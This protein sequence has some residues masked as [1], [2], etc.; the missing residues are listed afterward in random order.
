MTAY[1][2]TVALVAA[3]LLSAAG[4]AQDPTGIL[5]RP[6]PTPPERLMPV[7]HADAYR[8]AFDDARLGRLTRAR[9]DVRGLAYP[10]LDTAL[11]WVAL[12]RLF[13]ADFEVYRDFIETYPHWP[14]RERIERSAESVINL[15]VP[16]AD[17]DAWFSVHPPKTG[18]GHL[19]YAD[20]LFQ[21]GRDPAARRHLR[22]GWRTAPLTRSNQARIIGNWGGAL[23][24][25]DH[26]ARAHYWLWQRNRTQASRML[27]LLSADDRALVR[28]RL[29]LIAFA[30]GVDRRVDAVPDAL[31]NHAGLIYDRAYWRRVK[32]L[33]DAARDL[34]L[35]SDVNGAE[36]LRPKRWWRERH[37]QARKELKE[38]RYRNAYRLA[39]E[40]QLYEAIATHA[41]GIDPDASDAEDD[42]FGQA[43]E[44]V[45]RHLR[46]Q[47]AEAE[48]LAGWLALRFLDRP[49]EA[50]DHFRR[51]YDVVNFPVSIA[52][53]GYWTGR[54]AEARGDP[55]T[56]SL[57]YQRAAEHSAFYYGQLA[58]SRLGQPL[59]LPQQKQAVVT[60]EDRARFERD[61]RVQAARYLA[62]LDRQRELRWMIAHLVESAPTPG[63]RSLYLNLG[64]ELNRPDASLAAAKRLAR[65]G[66]LMVDAAY[67]VIQVP[68]RHQPRQPLILAI[69]RQESAFDPGA[70]SHAGAMG[71]MQL[72][73][74]TANLVARQLNRPFEQQ[75][76]VYDPSYNLELGATHIRDLLERYNGSIVLA[77]GAYN[78]GGRPVGRWLRDYGDPRLPDVDVVD[79]V[80][81][82]PYSETRNYVQRV[83]EAAVVYR[84][85]LSSN[86][87]P[88]SLE[89]MLNYGRPD[90]PR[91]MLMR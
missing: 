41:G 17:R 12:R 16:L 67:P 59:S 24:E 2:Y 71:L 20:T 48:F 87:N 52:R 28:A 83:M 40:H 23:S 39:A 15:G 54:A 62:H 19:A 66:E 86:G 60:A 50:L 29:S 3:L 42:G 18:R 37:Y 45:P 85:R 7:G 57:W 53:A 88:T 82:I 22:Q 61:D 46:A 33:D 79:W 70:V 74:P 84:A 31:S 9:R 43:S 34:L 36:I 26:Q 90:A 81:S 49:G 58:L 63:L 4:A 75:R 10:A 89:E 32:G 25:A 65:T 77:L 38:G 8:D 56:A 91:P 64:P 44:D 6:K 27:P 11:A 21:Q 51:V 78:A 5:P 80:E 55:I 35:D 47:I 1:R 76:L 69:T 30:T 73:P 72:T 14:D 68:E 13:A